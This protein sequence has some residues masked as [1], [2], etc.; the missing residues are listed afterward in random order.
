MK[1][2]ARILGAALAIGS[3]AAATTSAAPI[4]EKTA[5]PPTMSAIAKKMNGVTA[6]LARTITGEPTRK[7]QKAV[8]RDLDA[9]IAELEK[10]CQG[11][12]NGIASNRPMRPAA[13]SNPH[14]GTG[15]VGPLGDPG[16][17]EKDW[18]E[19][20]PRERDRIL[21]SMSEG[22]PPEYR[23]VLERYYRRLAEE[24]SAATTKPTEAP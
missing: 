11:C 4:P 12:R 24:R 15:G 2:Y 17:G 8:L 14:G 19:L 16:A 7:P 20:T 10:E 22:F 1:R 23:T 5:G 3:A 6:S 21:Q 18:A 13:D 9:L